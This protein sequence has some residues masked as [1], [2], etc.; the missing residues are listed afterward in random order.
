MIR[1][2]VL[3][4]VVC[5]VCEAQ[6]G[7]RQRQQQPMAEEP[8]ID[9]YKVL[10]LSKDAT[11]KEVK[12]AYREMSMKYHP[13][14]NKAANAQEKMQ[15]VSNAYEMIGDPDQKVI[16]DEFGGGQK[17]HSKWQYEMN[18]RQ[19]GMKTSK[20]DFYTH[21]EDVE[22][23]ETKTYYKFLNK[24]GPVMV[25]FYAPWCVH[26]QEMVGEYK[27][28]AIL[29]D[30]DGDGDGESKQ[31]AR[32]GAVNCE[33][34]SPVC[35]Q[36]GVRSYPTLRLFRPSD[37]GKMDMDE[38]S[39]DHTAEAMYSWVEMNL[40]PAM[41][42]LGADFE[43]VVLE[44]D[45]IWLVDFSAG[46]WCGPCT[47]LKSS[48]KET[49]H[50]LQGIA[51]IGLI[52]CDDHQE[53]CQSM[54]VGFYPQLRLF[55]KGRTNPTGNELSSDG[56]F[57]ASNTLSLFSQ[58]MHVLAPPPVEEAVESVSGMSEDDDEHLDEEYDEYHH[59]EL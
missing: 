25:E 30:G 14:K 7:R 50:A 2:L 40:S 38:Y 34:V 56:H 20:K 35:N 44:S 21:A 15:E 18:Q 5:C 8:S 54:N 10:G 1:T 9:P 53:V 52:N 51:K 11:P 47:M 39:G 48:V 19:K 27:K 28:L 37:G 46:Q 29:L 43:Q 59:T 6:Y 55:K 45:D 16:Y 41:V 23:L 31:K 4:V 36:N 33:R 13:D 32:L 17:F 3:L 12:K 26:C 42:N 24:G 49:A 22:N 58:I 57:P